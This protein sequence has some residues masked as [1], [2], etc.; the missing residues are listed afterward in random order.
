MGLFYTDNSTLKITAC[1]GGIY[2]TYKESW[3]TMFDL[4]SSLA[5]TLFKPYDNDIKTARISYGEY[6]KEPVIV[7]QMIIS[8]DNCVI[9]ELIREKDFNKHFE[10]NKLF[11]SLDVP[12]QIESKEMTQSIKKYLGIVRICLEDMSGA[13]YKLLSKTYDDYDYL[14]QWFKL[15]PEDEH[16]MLENNKKLDSM[17]LPFKDP[18]PITEEE[19]LET[20]KAQ[21]LYEE[22][23]H[24]VT[25]DE[26]NISTNPKTLIRKK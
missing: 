10:A 9:A 2:K 1:S 8:G 18:V 6:Q 23:F 24:N 25:C 12:K 15:Y 26:S 5:E 19:K 13:S 3:F 20:K 17:F 22:F 16:L 7:L 14:L 21:K 4:N 11:D